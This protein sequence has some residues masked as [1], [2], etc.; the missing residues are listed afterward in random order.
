MDTGFL[1][2]VRKCSGEV[3]V[4]GN[5]LKIAELHTFKG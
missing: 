4:V 2:W 1:S 3:V 5:V